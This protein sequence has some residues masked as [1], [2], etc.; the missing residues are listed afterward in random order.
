MVEDLHLFL[1]YAERP[2]VGRSAAGSGL[3][4]TIEL[5]TT[6]S[7]EVKHMKLSINSLV[8]SVGRAHDS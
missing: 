8:S 1:F 2:E 5:E 7:T 6:Q 3:A 4:R